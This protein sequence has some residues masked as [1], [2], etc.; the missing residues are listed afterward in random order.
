MGNWLMVTDGKTQ[1]RNHRRML[2]E[3]TY[4]SSRLIV[5]DTRCSTIIFHNFEQTLEQSIL[6]CN[7]DA[8]T[9][10]IIIITPRDIVPFRDS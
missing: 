10:E 8:L 5:A 6:C 9:A 1:S 7:A 4:Q 3:L 2:S